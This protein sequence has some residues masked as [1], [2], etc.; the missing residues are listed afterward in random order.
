MRDAYDRFFERL[1]VSPDA[2]FQFGLDEIIHV[3]YDVAAS[4]WNRLKQ[5]IDDGLRVT[6]RG[7]GRGG[8]N[9]HLFQRFY[10]DVLGHNDVAR[11]PTN[12]AMPTRVLRD[13]TGYSKTVKKGCE[14]IRN[15]QVSHVFGKTKNPYAFTA[16]W[17]IVYLPKI[18]DPFTGHEAP[19]SRSEDFTKLFQ[20]HMFALF[21]DL[22]QD[23]NRIVTN[24][25]LQT[26]IDSYIG[27]LPVDENLRA[28]VVSI[29]DEF[30]PI[31]LSDL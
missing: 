3:P 12:N 21:D 22:I 19:G 4:E 29:R 11:D 8:E 5:R 27:K 16:P 6:I 26:R 7:Y 15:Y 25:N 30:A 2:F 1:D 20:G 18:V 23:F 13:L 17:N 31:T 24:S 9:T 10:A 28:F 14:R